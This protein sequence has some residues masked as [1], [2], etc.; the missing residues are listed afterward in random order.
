MYTY[1]TVTEA[2]T[3][4]RRRG[5]TLDF[6][7][8][9]TA[10]NRPAL[11]LSLAPDT[12]VVDEWHRFEGESDPGDEMIVYALAARHRPEWRGTLL[13]AYGPDADGLSAQMV[14]RL[15]VVGP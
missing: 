8:T 15:S 2:L 12:F 6:N 13:N 1:E 10:L 5:Y 14:A 9:P 7:L 3:D 4:L 11:S